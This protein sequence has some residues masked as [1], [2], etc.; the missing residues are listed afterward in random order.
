MQSALKQ[1]YQREIIDKE[2]D[3]WFIPDRTLE[4]WGKTLLN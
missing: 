4:L 2:D 1:L 3:V